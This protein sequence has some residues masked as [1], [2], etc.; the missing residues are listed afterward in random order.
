MAILRR[1]GWRDGDRLEK[2]SNSVFAFG[3]LEACPLAKTCKTSG[4]FWVSHLGGVAVGVP[5]MVFI[6]CLAKTAMARSNKREIKLAF[7]GFHQRPGELADPSRVHTALLHSL[8]VLLPVSFG[9]LLWIVVDAKEKSPVT[10][11]RLR[12]GATDALANNAAKRMPAKTFFIG[13]S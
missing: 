5:K 10:I 3:R 7:V 9:P 12:L 6:P 2:C 1:Y 11:R 8:R 13:R 4:Y